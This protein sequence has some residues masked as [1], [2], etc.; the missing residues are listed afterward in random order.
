MNNWL[1]LLI[2]LSLL[3]GVVNGYRDGFV[4]LVIGFAALICAF[5]AASWFHGIVA[6]SFSEYIPSQAAASIAAYALI[7]AG[8]MAVGA[9]IASLIVRFFKLV[10]LTFVDRAL[11]AVFGVARAALVLIVVVMLLMAFAPSRMPAAVRDSQLAP[12]LIEASQVISSATPFEIRSE[13][14]RAYRALQ[15]RI[16]GLRMKKQLPVRQE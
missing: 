5:F 14:R 16:Q 6:G 3:I 4:R 8:V 1:D 7:F 15:D 10:G 12:W 2:A 13:V 9:L 11:G